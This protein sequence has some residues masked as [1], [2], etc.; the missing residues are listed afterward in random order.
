[1]QPLI[2][3]DCACA[4]ANLPRFVQPAL[5]AIVSQGPCHGYSILRELAQSGLFAACPPD[6]AGVYRILKNMEREGSLVSHW[7]SPETGPARKLYTITERG[8]LCLQTWRETLIRHQ[9]FLAS[10]QEF[11]GNS[12]L[13]SV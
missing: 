7:D 11:I 1:M 4:G 2:M 9:K 8:R 10:L 5:L 12:P 3:S 6:T 13:Q